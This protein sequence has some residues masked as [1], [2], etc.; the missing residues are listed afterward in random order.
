MYLA[1]INISGVTESFQDKADAEELIK[2][3]WDNDNVSPYTTLHCHNIHTVFQSIFYMICYEE[4]PPVTI[5]VEIR[6]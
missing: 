2:L 5:E 4:E 3:V 1:G 6:E